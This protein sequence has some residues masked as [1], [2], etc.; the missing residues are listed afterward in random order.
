[1]LFLIHAKF[2]LNFLMSIR[3][4]KI[5]SEFQRILYKT[6]PTCSRNSIRNFLKKF[7]KNKKFTQN[8]DDGS[9]KFP[10]ISLKFC[11]SFTN[12]FLKFCHTF[13]KFCHNITFN[14]NLLLKFKY[15]F[16]NTEIFFKVSYIEDF[17]IFQRKYLPKFYL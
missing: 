15:F 7:K 16:K 13:L 11:F 8:L 10:Q 17:N 3:F 12:D 4:L 9:R 2:L 1:M 14:R 6:F 5:S